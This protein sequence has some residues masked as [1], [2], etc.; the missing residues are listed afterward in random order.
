MQKILIIDD[1]PQILELLSSI[2]LDKYIVETITDE[3]VEKK[4]L[5]SFDLIISDFCMPTITGLDIYKKNKGMIK[6]SFIIF[7][8]SI[9]PV[10]TKTEKEI[11]FIEKPLIKDLFD[12]VDAILLK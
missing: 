4:D 9:T 1:E 7:S 5:S 3:F 2:L 6:G 11:H 8:G 10:M 12:K